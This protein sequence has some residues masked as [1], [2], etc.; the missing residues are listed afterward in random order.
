MNGTTVIILI[1]IVLLLLLQQRLGGA[2][3][4]EVQAASAAGW[5]HH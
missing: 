2:K 5:S 3:T 4:G 1:V